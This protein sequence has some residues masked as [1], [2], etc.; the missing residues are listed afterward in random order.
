M[1]KNVRSSGGGFISLWNDR[2]KWSLSSSSLLVPQCPEHG[3]WERDAA[4]IA[5]S[6]ASQQAENSHPPISYLLQ[7]RLRVGR[8]ICRWHFYRLAPLL[9]NTFTNEAHLTF[10]VFTKWLVLI[11]LSQSFWLKPWILFSRAQWPRVP[12]QLFASLNKSN[13]FRTRKPKVSHQHP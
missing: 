10:S 6:P 11:L 7:G 2:F 13:M 5:G 12:C 9:S 4:M 8:K 1:Y 3:G